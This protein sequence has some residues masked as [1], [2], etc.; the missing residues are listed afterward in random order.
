[1]SRPLNDDERAELVEFVVFAHLIGEPEAPSID[2]N[3]D[4]SLTDEEREELVRKANEFIESIW[5]LQPTAPVFASSEMAQ[6]YIRGELPILPE[7]Y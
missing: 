3:V 1:M 6:A 5:E 4:P 2:Q 7:M